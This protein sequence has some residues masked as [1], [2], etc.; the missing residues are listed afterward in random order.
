MS[1]NHVDNSGSSEETCS[2]LED[3]HNSVSDVMYSSYTILS[4]VIYILLG[5]Q[6]WAYLQKLHVFGKLYFS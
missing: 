1:D 5:L 3:F 2:G 6:N 4:L